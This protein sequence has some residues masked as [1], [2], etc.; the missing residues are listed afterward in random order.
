MKKFKL[1]L[2][3][4]IIGI[5]SASGL[6]YKNDSL[7]IISDDSNYLY[8]YSIANADLEKHLLIENEAVNEN[9]P[10]N[11]KSDFE[12]ITQF[13]DDIFVVGSGST[14]VRNKMIQMSDLQKRVLQ[15]HDLTDLY[16]S[17]HYFAGISA[18]EFNIEGVIFTGEKWYFF[19]RGNGKSAQNGIFTIE[20]PYFRQG[21]SMLYASYDLPKI[22]GVQ[23]S[24]TDAILVDDSFYFL[25]SAEDSQSTYLD[26]EVV[27]SSIGRINIETMK[28]KEVVTVTDTHK[29]EGLTLYKN[30]AKTL[31]FLLCEDQD[32][33]V[34]ESQIFK[35]TLNK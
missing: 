15:N 27:G 17:M 7:Y 10:K 24:F 14:I 1:D 6:V 30:N 20:S 26:G 11:V 5:S 12:A 32:D 18:E 19:Q 2:F 25:A 9:I 3:L 34:M 16:L 33:E 29:F 4:K 31:E 28:L 35:L 21:Y 22:N 8:E 13:D 23:A